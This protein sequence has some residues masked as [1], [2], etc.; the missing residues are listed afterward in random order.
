MTDLMTVTP[1]APPAPAGLDPTL[2]PAVPFLNWVARWYDGLA[3]A[4]LA[5]ITAQPERVA[6]ISVDLLN[7]FCYEGPLS[8]PRVAGIVEPIAA[9]FRAAYDAG[10]RRFVLTQD[11]HDPAAPEFAAWGPH[12]VRGTPEA[13]TVDA[14]KNLPWFQEHVVVFEKNST[15]S[16]HHTGLAAWLDAPEQRE[17]DTFVVV[18]DCTDIC[19][20]LLALDLKLRANAAGRRVRVIVPVD[21]VDTYDMPVPLAQQ[22]GIMPHD[23]DFLHRLFLYHMAL[24][25]VEVVSHVAAPVSR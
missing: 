12:C 3:P 24:N 14:L 6:V 2:A 20:Y 15:S 5:T 18:G 16:L 8:G 10:V 11:T 22:L 7:G 23:A 13:E 21:C 17:V 4:D 25:G 19:T 9:L 1:A